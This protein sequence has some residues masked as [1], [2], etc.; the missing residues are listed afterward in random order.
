VGTGQVDWTAFVR[1]L[2][3][4]DYQGDYIFEREAGSD[5]VGDITQGIAALTAAMSQVASA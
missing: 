4:A 2:A 5:R 1:I 3:Q